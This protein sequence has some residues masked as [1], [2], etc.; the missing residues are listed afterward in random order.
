MFC[1]IIIMYKMSFETKKILV[2]IW[3]HFYAVFTLERFTEVL[4]LTYLGIFFACVNAN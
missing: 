4:Q 1:L 3:R 2:V